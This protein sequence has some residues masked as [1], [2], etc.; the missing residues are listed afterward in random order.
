[1]DRYST[2]SPVAQAINMRPKAAS[3]QIGQG[4]ICS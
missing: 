2:L 3:N 4:L 1:V